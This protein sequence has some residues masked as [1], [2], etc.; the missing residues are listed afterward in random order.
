[1]MNMALM[2]LVVVAMVGKK[3]ERGR[4]GQGQVARG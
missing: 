4:R 3:V 2:T 1:M